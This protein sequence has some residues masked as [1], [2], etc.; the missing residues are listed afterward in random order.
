MLLTYL[1]FV[2]NDADLSRSANSKGVTSVNVHT[3]RAT[4]VMTPY[5]TA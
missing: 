4:E 1:D 3:C 2:N 5:S